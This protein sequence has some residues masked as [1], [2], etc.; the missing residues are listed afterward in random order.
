MKNISGLAHSSVAVITVELAGRAPFLSLSFN[1]YHYNMRQY[2][3]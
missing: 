3:K 1:F 2:N